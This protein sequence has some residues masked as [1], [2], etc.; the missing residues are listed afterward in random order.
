MPWILKG[1]VTWVR[2]QLLRKYSI[3][4]L[5]NDDVWYFEVIE[6]PEIHFRGI[7]ETD[8]ALMYDY[9]SPSAL[10]IHEIQ[11]KYGNQNDFTVVLAN[12]I[13]LY[14]KAFQNAMNKLKVV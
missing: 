2:D 3:D 6:A 13:D 9:F 5:N 11:Q 12:L 7:S 8:I 10:E 14:Q 4:Q 1:H